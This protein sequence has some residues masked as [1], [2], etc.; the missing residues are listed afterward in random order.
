[1]VSPTPEL[2][3][4]AYDY[5]VLAL[6]TDWIGIAANDYYASPSDKT[7]YLSPLETNFEINGVNS[8]VS[9]TLWISDLFKAFIN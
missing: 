8:F 6:A 7:A 3:A 9:F 5:D 1:M 2:T 4:I